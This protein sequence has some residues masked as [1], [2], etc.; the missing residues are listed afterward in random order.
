ML[1]A[2]R[3]KKT[4]QPGVCYTTGR[5]A[6]CPDHLLKCRQRTAAET[7]DSM[8]ALDNP[9]CFLDI[10][11]GGTPEGR[12]SVEL[13]ADVVPRYAC[14][15]HS[16]LLPE[17]C[18][19]QC[20]VNSWSCVAGQ[21]RTSGACAQG[22]REWDS[23]AGSCG[24]KAALSTASSLTSCARQVPLPD[25]QA[26]C[27]LRRATAVRGTGPVACVA[28]SNHACEVMSGHLNL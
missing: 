3:H 11:I 24:S 13:F 8:A 9:R 27:R 14:S 17:A 7:Q 15:A 26:C 1:G 19:S 28:Y 22:R 21:L 20:S 2:R 16:Q 4:K 12:I 6:A 5:Q 18:A 10:D 25:R 23:L